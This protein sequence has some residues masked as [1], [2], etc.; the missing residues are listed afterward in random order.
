MCAVISAYVP[1]RTLVPTMIMWFERRRHERAAGT[2]APFWVQPLVALQ[3]GFEKAFDRFREAYANLLGTV[4]GHRAAFVVGFLS[5]CVATWLIVPFLGQNFFP[6]VD[7]GTF[8][9]H[10]RAPT[11][12]RIEQTAKL[13]D[14]VGAAIRREVPA[15]EMEG[16][17]DNIGLPVSGINLSYND[18]GISGPADADILVSLKPNHK[19]TANYVRNLRLSLNRE[20][21]GTTFYFLP[22]GIVSQ[23]LH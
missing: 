1:S 11:G 2:H 8:R 22:A 19:P 23:T 10:V 15:N 7:A 3:Q 17:L 21:P 13:V 20:F 5:F 6:A 14:E 9:L 16:I 12:P 18:S 4:L